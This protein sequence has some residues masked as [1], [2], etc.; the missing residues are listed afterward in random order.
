M[1]TLADRVFR[2]KLQMELEPTDFI[3]KRFLQAN[4]SAYLKPQDLFVYLRT[5]TDRYWT[6]M[7]QAVTLIYEWA[8]YL[9]VPDNINDLKYQ[10]WENFLCRIS[11]DA[12][13]ITG[14]SPAE[15]HGN[16]VL[17]I[18][19]ETVET[20]LLSR[21][22]VHQLVQEQQQQQQL[23]HHQPQH[24]LLSPPPPP[25]QAS[26]LV[27]VSPLP[28]SLQAFYAQQQQQQHQDLN[29]KEMATLQRSLQ[30]LVLPAQTQGMPIK[31]RRTKENIDYYPAR[32]RKK[33]PTRHERPSNKGSR[34]RKQM[35]LSRSARQYDREDDDDE[36]EDGDDDAAE[37]DDDDDDTRDP[38]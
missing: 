35:S 1:A 16:E 18:L 29:T 38:E 7:S 28:S 21:L 25:P 24:Q 13:L 10:I 17:R 36:E 26:P 3:L 12:R 2:A 11:L 30:Q 8:Q 4:P 19:I 14:R 32:S 27:E 23:Q 34:S 20:T 37:G 15:S 9:H 22:S 31:L 33:K 6:E 5:L